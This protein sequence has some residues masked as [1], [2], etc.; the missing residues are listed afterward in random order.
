MNLDRVTAELAYDLVQREV[1]TVAEFQAWHIFKLKEA[2]LLQ[3]TSEYVP[4]FR[5]LREGNQLKVYLSD[6]VPDSSM[7]V[8]FNHRLYDSFD[9]RFE[10]YHFE[11]VND[12]YTPHKHLPGFNVQY[13]TKENLDK[14]WTRIVKMAKTAVA[15]NLD[16]KNSEDLQYL[17]RILC[18]AVHV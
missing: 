8:Y 7:V 15:Y 1:W 2:D 6:V 10:V 12:Y 16:E 18:P 5:Q 17:A 3:S 4:D 9:V 14:A 13:K 11:E